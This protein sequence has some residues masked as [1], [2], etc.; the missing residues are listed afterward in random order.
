MWTICKQGMP[1]YCC[2]TRLS[3]FI[4]CCRKQVVGVKCPFSKKD[5]SLRGQK[6]FYLQ[7]DIDGKRHLDRE[8]DFFFQIQTQMGVTKIDSCLFV[9]WTTVDFHVEQVLF[10]TDL[11]QEICTRA[12][13]FFYTALLPELVGK[14]CTRLPGLGPSTSIYVPLQP[15]TSTLDET[16]DNSKI[17]RDCWC[18][19][20]QKEDTVCC[21]N[22]NC[23]NKWFYS[24]CLKLGT[25]PKSNYYT[26]REIKPVRFIECKHSK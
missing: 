3:Y 7:K 10:D 23:D 26:R 12:E 4:N 18:Y 17:E 1:N 21:D 24:D 25:Q 16:V 20:D 14:F 13:H 15:L 22:D 8:H 2:N 5:D 11:L 19:C 6:N 9:V